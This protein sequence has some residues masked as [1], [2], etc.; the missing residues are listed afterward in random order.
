[1]PKERNGLLTPKQEELADDLYDANG[2][3]EL[4]DGPAIKIADNVGL[5]KLKEL[6]PVEFHQTLYDIVDQIFL[7]LATKTK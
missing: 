3:M 1:M 2:I 7:M 4:I 6:I 5:Q